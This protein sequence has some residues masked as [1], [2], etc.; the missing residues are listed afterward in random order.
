[1]R[2]RGAARFRRRPALPSTAWRRAVLDSPN[3]RHH[4]VRDVDEPTTLRGAP[5]AIRQVA[6]DGLGHPQPTRCVSHNFDASARDLITRATGRNG[7][8]ESLGISGHVFPLDCLAS[9]VR[10]NVAVDV[11]LT[12]LAQGCY[13]WFATQWHGVDKAKPKQLYRKFVDT[14]GP[15]D[16]QADRL[17][18]RCDNRAHKP[19]LRDA[20][21]DQACPPLPWWPHLPVTFASP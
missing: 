20:A 16:I 18:V 13:R 5:G 19:L 21:L 4:H 11:A 3:R 8:E 7:V 17:V 6:V 1:M 10:R 9:A 14:G 15:L 2:R 12:V